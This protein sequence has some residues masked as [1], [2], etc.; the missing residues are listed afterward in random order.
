MIAL[1]NDV[2]RHI[3]VIDDEIAPSVR[4]ESLL[5]KASIDYSSI[6]YACSFYLDGEK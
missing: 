1:D 4:P 5:R 3:K 2:D 6:T